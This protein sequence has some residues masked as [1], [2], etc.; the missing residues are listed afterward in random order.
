[1]YANCEAVLWVARTGA[2][3]Q[4]LPDYNGPWSSAYSFFWRS[5]L[6]HWGIGS[7]LS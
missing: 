2:S 7:A 1:M 5:W 4:Y 3:W 6:M